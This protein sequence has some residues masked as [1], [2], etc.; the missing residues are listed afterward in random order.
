MDVVCCCRRSLSHIW[1]EKL[2]PKAHSNFNHKRFRSFR[3]IQS[4][5]TRNNS[6]SVKIRYFPSLELFSDF[7]L[8]YFHSKWYYSEKFIALARGEWWTTTTRSTPTSSSS[9]IKTKAFFHVLVPWKCLLTVYET[10]HR[11]WSFFSTHSFL[12]TRRRELIVWWFFS[13]YY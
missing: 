1:S 6:A 10:F 7:S 13:S 9:S 3:H 11:R 8:A 5:T 12:L 2:K 4:A